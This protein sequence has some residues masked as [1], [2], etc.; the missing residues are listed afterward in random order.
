H[1]LAVPS[2]HDALPIWRRIP[3]SIT[4]SA[5]YC[6]S[7]RRISRPLHEHPMGALRHG[8]SGDEPA[9]VSLEAASLALELLRGVDRGVAAQLGRDRKSTRL[10]SSHVKI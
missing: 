6:L 5:W 8:R 2:L 9:D 1:L 7:D 10:N 4:S 3:T